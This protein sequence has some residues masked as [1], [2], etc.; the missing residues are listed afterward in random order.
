MYSVKQGRHATP[1]TVPHRVKN[2]TA[3]CEYLTHWSIFIVERDSAHVYLCAH[4]WNRLFISPRIRATLQI[5]TELYFSPGQC[6]QHAIN[7]TNG[8]PT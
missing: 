2:C 5:A 1:C 6:H 7:H 4:F 8:G 3:M